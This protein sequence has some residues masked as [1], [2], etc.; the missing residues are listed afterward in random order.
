MLRYAL[1]CY[2]VPCGVQVPQCSEP[3]PVPDLPMTFETRDWVV[4]S[5]FLPFL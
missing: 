1:T 5:R 3:G 2:A 4:V